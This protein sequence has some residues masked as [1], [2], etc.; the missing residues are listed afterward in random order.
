M[1]MGERERGRDR[2]IYTESHARVIGE[3][4]QFGYGEHRHSIDRAAR[5]SRSVLN[6]VGFR[7]RKE[8]VGLIFLNFRLPVSRGMREI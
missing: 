4:L 6:G 7:E 1:S 8:M 2:Y 3:R 5:D